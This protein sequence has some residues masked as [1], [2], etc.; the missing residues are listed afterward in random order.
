MKAAQLGSGQ[1]TV[2]DLGVCL[3]CQTGICE[4]VAAH[5]GSVDF[6]DPA[7]EGQ[8]LTSSL[9]AQGCLKYDE[10]AARIPQYDGY[11]VITFKND[12]LDNL[13]VISDDQSD[14]VYITIVTRCGAFD[15][16][17]NANQAGKFSSVRV[18]YR[19]YHVYNGWSLN[20]DP[21]N[22]DECIWTT[23]SHVIE[24]IW[25]AIYQRRLTTNEYWASGDYKL[26]RVIPPI[27]GHIGLLDAG[28][29]DPACP[30]PGPFYPLQYCSSGWGQNV[31]YQGFVFPWYPPDSVELVRVC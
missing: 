16:C 11:N 28:C 20:P 17:A 9:I 13:N 29:V 10:G 22:P 18:E 23:Q 27:Q 19:F 15:G 12:S 26:V 8:C 14:V 31:D 1:Q 25:T 21:A 30:S 3:P 5:E 2:S 7:A 6:P 24:Q 4:V